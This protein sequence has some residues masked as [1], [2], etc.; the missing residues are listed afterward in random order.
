MDWK[1]LFGFGMGAVAVLSYAGLTNGS[2]RRA[3]QHPSSKQLAASGGSASIPATAPSK[4][5][6]AAAVAS[7]EPKSSADIWAKAQP[8]I[9]AE[10]EVVGVY[11]R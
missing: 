3:S 8:H 4:P 11:E 10:A 6:V 2:E 1:A 7:A 9:I 5:P